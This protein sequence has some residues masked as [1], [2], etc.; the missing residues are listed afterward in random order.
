[1][2]PPLPLPLP[3]PQYAV[4]AGAPVVW[5]SP[6]GFPVE[7]PYRKV[8]TLSV[9]TSLQVGRRCVCVCVEGG[10]VPAQ[11]RA[12]Q[13]KLAEGGEGGAVHA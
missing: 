9:H 12:K 10:Y 13:V 1:M 8:P 7:Q 4:S 11:T 2:Q 3:S 5:T 6:L